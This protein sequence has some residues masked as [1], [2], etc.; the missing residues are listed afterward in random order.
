MRERGSGVHLCV[1]GGGGVRGVQT[2]VEVYTEIYVEVYIDSGR[3]V[4]RQR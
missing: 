2:V 4:F 3:S 1:E